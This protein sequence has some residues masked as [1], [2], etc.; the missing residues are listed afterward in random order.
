[1]NN[2][3]TVLVQVTEKILRD[4]G[5]T[6]EPD[7]RIKP[8]I[9]KEQASNALLVSV[10]LAMEDYIEEKINKGQD[11]MADKIRELINTVEQMDTINSKVIASNGFTI[12]IAGKDNFNQHQ[13]EYY[14]CTRC[15]WLLSPDD[16]LIGEVPFTKKAK[17]LVHLNDLFKVFIDGYVETSGYESYEDTK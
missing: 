14:K 15:V 5:E 3:A 6:L 16:E 8:F 17:K 7:F 9:N 12:F 11:D 1:M 13:I 10:R 2:D 4:G